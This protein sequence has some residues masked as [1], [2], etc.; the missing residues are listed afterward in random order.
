[1]TLHDKVRGMFLG[2]GVGDALGVPVE[3]WTRDRIKDAY[4]E[5]VRD[6]KIPSGHKW[7][8]GQPAGEVSDDTSLTIATA[9]GLIEAGTFD[10]DAQARQMV[11]A[12]KETIKKKGKAGGS[13]VPGWGY[14]TVKAVRNLANNIPWNESGKTTDPNLGHGN[15]VVMRQSPIAIW[16]YLM[17]QQFDKRDAISFHQKLIDFSATTHYTNQSA[18]ATVVHNAVLMNCLSDEPYSVDND[19]IAI[20]KLS[21][22]VFFNLLKTDHLVTTKIDMWKQFD[23]VANSKGWDTDKI[24]AEFGGGSCNVGHSLP[25]CYAFWINN[26]STTQLL[27]DIVEAGGDTDTNASIVGSMLGA[28]HGESIFPDHLVNGLVDKDEILTLADRFCAKF[29]IN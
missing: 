7:F 9:K 15:G 4:P 24:I 16:A 21:H 5:G 17:E 11:L 18:I 23:K 26:H 20:F 8:D 19:L 1:M 6:Y 13:G 29:G 27:Y 14:T 25:F 3:T 10:L 2:I 28:L 12:M 22:S